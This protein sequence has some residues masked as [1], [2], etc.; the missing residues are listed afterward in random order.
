MG[1]RNYRRQKAL[2]LE[3]NAAQ[4]QRFQADLAPKA[5]PM[6]DSYSASEVLVLVLE[7]CRET[8]YEQE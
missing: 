3:R 8:F 1:C 7:L 4:K 5:S 6:S 2:W